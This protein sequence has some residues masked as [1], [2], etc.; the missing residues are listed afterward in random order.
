MWITGWS[1][2]RVKTLSYVAVAKFDQIM[3]E[4]KRNWISH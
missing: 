1:F 4:I 3:V 2:A